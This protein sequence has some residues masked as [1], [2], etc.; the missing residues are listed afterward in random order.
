MKLEP[1]KQLFVSISDIANG[2]E[3]VM[4]M[5]AMSCKAP[6]LFLKKEKQHHLSM[7]KEQV[8]IYASQKHILLGLLILPFKLLPYRKNYTIMSTHPY[9]NAYLGLLKRIKFL[10]SKL[11][12]RE[13]SSIFTRYKGIKRFS[14]SAVYR[15]GYP[16]VNLVIC[17]TD[18]M[19]ND[20][21]HHNHFFPE[22][23]IMV[24]GNPIN[25]M[26]LIN[27]STSNI[28]NIL[29]YGNYI[30]AAGRLIP[31]KGFDTLIYAFKLVKK[32][33]PE[34]NLLILG[35]GPERNKLT[36][37][38]NELQ[39]KDSVILMGWVENPMPYFKHA[40]ACIMSSVKE[41]FPNVLLQMM[42]L[43]TNVISTRCAGGIS[44]IPGI[45]TVPINNPQAL[46]LAI[47]AVL[48]KNTVDAPLQK[49][50]YLKKRSPKAFLE[51][52]FDAL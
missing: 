40:K 11:V 41:G 16:G 14:Y 32:L 28:N 6:I 39:L 7:P 37:L 33:K 47:A 3:Q 50:E 31:E 15:M 8:T 4:L 52:I 51:S 24:S 21:I 34:L 1:S 20:F 36:N 23:K 45:L 12:V 22:R 46:S 35:E 38:I 48:N 19:K 30:C 42:V 43:N 44:E 25:H 18:Q 29:D 10:N 9:V 49:A 26:A 13:C 2:A 17:Q 5:S 27:A